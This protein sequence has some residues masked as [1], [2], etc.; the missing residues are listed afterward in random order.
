MMEKKITLQD[1][2]KNA[3]VTVGTVHKALHNKKGVSPEKREEILALA[4]SLNYCPAALPDHKTVKIAA[5]FPGPSNDN[6]FFYQYIWKGI[7]DRAGELKP[8]HFEVMDFTFE[9]GLE[10]QLELLNHI[11]ANHRHEITGLLTVIWNE[12]ASLEILNKFTQEGIRIFTLSADA[13]FSQRT[14]CIM[15]NPYRTGRLA[16]EYLGSLLNTPCRIVIIGTKRD[17]N[18]HAQVVRGFFDQMTET[19][20]LIEIIELYESVNYPEK[21]YETLS[22]FLHT[23][24]NILGIYA[25]NARTTARVCSMIQEIGYQNKVKIIGSELF[26]ESEEALKNGTLNAIIDQNGYE[27]GYKGISIAFDHI[28]LGNPVASK[29]NI[30]SALILKNNLP[31]RED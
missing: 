27:Q 8:C 12:T 2:A 17:T 31:L 3:H 14:S 15:A 30:N 19:N 26:A 10:Q 9:G 7:H 29:Y 28:V 25:N 4:S 22:E 6:R 11:W 23:F 21:L 24:D 20:P 5:V 16:A 13:P 1:I 18:N